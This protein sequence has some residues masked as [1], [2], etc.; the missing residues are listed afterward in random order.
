MSNT[1]NSIVESDSVVE[2]MYQDYLESQSNDTTIA[3]NN[4]SIQVMRHSDDMMT[5]M[6]CAS[7]MNS[8]CHLTKDGALALADA[9][10]QIMGGR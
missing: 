8:C 2:E 10:T 1:K 3:D 4:L 7:G 6:V 5:V 9:I